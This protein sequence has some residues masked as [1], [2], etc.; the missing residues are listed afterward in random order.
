MTEEDLTDTTSTEETIDTT[1]RPQ[2][3]EEYFFGGEVKNDF[4]SAMRIFLQA[5]KERRDAL[6]HVLFSGPPG[7][8]KTTLAHILAQ[9]MNVQIKVTS[10]PAIERTGDLAS[11]LTSLQEG[12][13]LF[14]D[15]VHRLN[16]AVEETLYPA[17]EDFCLDIV[18]GKGPSA[19][20]IRLEMPPFTIV[21]ATTRM[22]LLSAPLRDRFGVTYRLDFFEEPDLTRIIE[23]SARLLGAKVTKDGCFEIA[24]RSRGTPRIANRLIK[25]IRDF[26]QVKRVE[27]IN[28]DLVH[29]ALDMLGVDEAGLNK[30]DR[31]YLDILVNKYKGGPVGLTTLASAM[32]EHAGTLEEVIEPYL[33]Q[34]GFIK[35]TAQ[36]RVATSR[37]FEHLGI[38]LDGVENDRRL[39]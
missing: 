9:E 39:L 3:L 21:G 30:S 26:S 18:L 20:T 38:P 27:T 8:G 13:I 25:R 12:D 22:G 15:E 16:K 14:I 36:G 33:L 32:A 28:P 7:L 2:S 31:Q 4:F 35:K 6:D 29:R 24:K 11:I 1:L 34:R 37:A 5:A 23:R 17:M 19:Q 10:G